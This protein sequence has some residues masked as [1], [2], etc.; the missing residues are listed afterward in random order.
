VLLSRK[1][2]FLD[3]TL[4]NFSSSYYFIGCAWISKKYRQ[5]LFYYFEMGSVCSTI[6]QEDDGGAMQDAPHIVIDVTTCGVLTDELHSRHEI[7]ETIAS[8]GTQYAT[9]S[10]AMILSHSCNISGHRNVTIN[11]LNPP[12]RGAG[13]APSSARNKC[14]TSVIPPS[15]SV[16]SAAARHV[17][18]NSSGS[19]V[20]LVVATVPAASQ[21]FRG[22]RAPDELWSHGLQA[23]PF[24][25]DA[26]APPRDGD[27][28][29]SPMSPPFSM[30]DH[31]AA[32][33]VVATSAA[34]SC[35]GS[36][37]PSP[38]DRVPQQLCVIREADKETPQRRHCLLPADA[39]NIPERV[40]AHHGILSPRQHRSTLI[41]GSQPFT[42]LFP[43]TASLSREAAARPDGPRTSP[44]PT[45]QPSWLMHHECDKRVA[46]LD[47][48]HSGTP[49]NS[50][51][52]AKDGDDHFAHSSNV[53]ELPTFGVVFSFALPQFNNR[54]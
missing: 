22:E 15:C 30:L 48:S 5:N 33:V 31:P 14:T 2:T 46:R 3:G 53:T 19:S 44:S 16:V 32:A 6:P 25:N 8:G 40:H 27:A 21:S 10:H 51:C 12:L 38:V 36:C 4:P 37:H 42:S 49:N 11:P 26:P 34:T 24:V 39:E 47:S 45:Q 54:L 1:T 43:S 23:L 20:A 17:C 52:S 7:G 28:A 50:L 9:R 41:T 29:V 13:A 35:R 18:E